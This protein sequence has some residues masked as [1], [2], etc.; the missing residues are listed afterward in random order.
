[1][2]LSCE[3]L[4]THSIIYSLQVGVFVVYSTYLIV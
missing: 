2:R 3:I 4:D 1:M